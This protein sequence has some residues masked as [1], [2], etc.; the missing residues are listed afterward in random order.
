ME[1]DGQPAGV[2][3]LRTIRAAR[4]GQEGQRQGAAD[5]AVDEIAERQANRRGVAGNRVHE[6][7]E[8]AAEIGTQHHRERGDGTDEAS[9]GQ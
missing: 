2:G 5:E 9:G 6:R 1:D 3:R 8:G 4:S 7:I